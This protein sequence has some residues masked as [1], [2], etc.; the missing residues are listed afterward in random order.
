MASALPKLIGVVGAGQMGAG[1]A[2]VAA[3]CGFSVLLVDRGFEQ[4]VK[5]QAAIRDS[6]SRLAKKGRLAEPEVEATLGR[7]EAATDLAALSRADYIIE[8][9][10]E[11]EQLKCAVFRELDRLLPQDSILAS[12]TSSIRC[13][14]WPRLCP[15]LWAT[16]TLHGQRQA[17]L[18]L[19]AASLGWR[20]PQAGRI[21]LWDSTL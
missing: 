11:S 15:R 2:Q 7:L 4:L 14:L 12:N 6:L 16:G 13:G 18:S 8:A 20:R 19:F 3:A 17:P 10:P 9:V 1:I 5:A 21:R